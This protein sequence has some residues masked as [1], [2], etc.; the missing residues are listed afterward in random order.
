MGV[1]KLDSNILGVLNRLRRRERDIHTAFERTLDGHQWFELLKNKASMTL[2][3]TA[4]LEEQPMVM[5]FLRT[6]LS[7]VLPMGFFAELRDPQSPILGVDAFVYASQMQAE[8][9]GRGLGPGLFSRALNDWDQMIEDWV[10]TEKDKDKRD[11][12]KT[13][14]DIARWISYAL[15]HPECEWVVQSGKNAGKKV[16][17]VFL[18]HITKWI[19]QRQRS[20]RLPEE[21]VDRWLRE[22][23]AAWSDLVRREVPR[24]FMKNYDAARKEL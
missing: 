6:F 22:V 1:L 5:A 24:R 3:Q 20:V 19:I 17:D 16:R 15:L 8:D 12:D 7:D 2:Q 14:A 9:A 10:A 4:T 11:W 21:K 18:P 13:D 23:L